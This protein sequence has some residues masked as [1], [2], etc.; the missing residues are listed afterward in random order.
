M[1]LTKN[2]GNPLAKT[3]ARKNIRR[4]QLG[5]TTLQVH[6][7]IQ[8]IVHALVTS[9][10]AQ[11]PPAAKSWQPPEQ[12]ETLTHYHYGLSFE[13]PAHLAGFEKFGFEEDHDYLVFTRSPEEA[14]RLADNV[15]AARV[16]TPPRVE[17][18][19][20]KH[21]TPGTRELKPGDK[22]DD[23]VFLQL[24]TGCPS[25]GGTFDRETAAYVRLLN[26]RLGVG[27]DTAHEETWL[28]LLRYRS[29]HVLERGNT[30]LRVRVFQAALVAY[31]W[32]NNLEITGWFDRP[33]EQAVRQMQETLGLRVTGRVRLPEWTAALEAKHD[34]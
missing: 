23:V 6:K 8:D 29:N 25:H 9:H 30:G 21:C 18:T 12:G 4:V 32:D 31:D 10:G 7:D 26:E 17:T 16:S 2:W 28:G 20:W 27:G 3:F 24:A 19:L 15:E 22:G 13:K 14:Q 11:L 5:L 33:T 1:D 34:T